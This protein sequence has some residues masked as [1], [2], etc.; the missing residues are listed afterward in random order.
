MLENRQILL[1]L[2]QRKSG[3][4]TQEKLHGKSKNAVLKNMTLTGRVKYT[5]M[6]GRVVFEDK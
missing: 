1:F 3:L 4:W 6:N 5:I 2:T